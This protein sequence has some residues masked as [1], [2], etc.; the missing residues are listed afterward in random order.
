MTYAFGK[1]KENLRTALAL[2]FWFYNFARIHGT[3]RVTPAVESGIID[4][5]WTIQELIA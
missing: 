2:H 1:K 3:L 4:H 5:I